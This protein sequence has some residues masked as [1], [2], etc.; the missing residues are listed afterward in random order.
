[1]DKSFSNRASRR[2]RTRRHRRV[3]IGAAAAAAALVAAAGISVGHG[4][5]SSGAASP[6][7]LP[8]ASAPRDVGGA[9]FGFVGRA[10][11]PGDGGSYGGYAEGYPGD[12]SGA[13]AGGFGG[14]GGWFAGGYP[15]WSA[16][17]YPGSGSGS[18]S[19]GL[20]GS[21]GSGGYAGEGSGGDTGGAQTGSAATAAESKGVVL[22]G[23]EIDGG[24]AEAAGTGMVLTSGGEILTN[25]HVVSGATAI[26]VEVASTGAVY[27]AHVIGTD[28]GDDVA[29]L[30]V[31]GAPPLATATFGSSADAQ[32]GD[33]VTGVG[34]AEGGGQLVTATGQVT[35]LDQS[36][37]TQAEQL[38]ASESLSGLIEDD[39]AIEPGDSGGPLY[40]SAGDIVGMDTAASDGGAANSYAIPISHALAVAHAIVSDAGAGA[41]QSGGAGA[42]AGTAFSA[43]AVARV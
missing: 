42:A 3:V 20:G 10:A 39:A 38:E 35:G 29:V 8:Q 33:D 28:V 36:I 19:G 43:A 15:G 17:G 27:D 1:M 41:G 30:Q 37:T 18:E 24:E 6:A 11:W 9:A 25:N 26:E 16:G 40:D 31:Q 2:R 7:T 21:G 5:T 34:N 13:Y 14:Y 32:V 12:S 23:T 22:I 4:V